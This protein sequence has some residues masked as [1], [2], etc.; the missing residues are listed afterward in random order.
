MSAPDGMIVDVVGGYTTAGSDPR[1]VINSRTSDYIGDVQ[2][3]VPE[4]EKVKAFGDSTYIELDYVIPQGQYPLFSYYLR[5]QRVTIVQ[6]IG[7]DGQ[8]TRRGVTQYKIKAF[9]RNYDDAEFKLT[10]SKPQIS[11]ASRMKKKEGKNQKNQYQN[12]VP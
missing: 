11:S 1:I 2:V 9:N 4:D 6:V 12:H 5:H 10:G 7:K 8:M 3:G